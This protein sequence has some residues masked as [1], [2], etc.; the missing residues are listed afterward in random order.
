MCAIDLKKWAAGPACPTVP[1]GT[2]V[3]V[4]VWNPADKA[5]RMITSLPYSDNRMF[6]PRVRCPEPL[7][8]RRRR[9][10]QPG[11]ASDDHPDCPPGRA[12]RRVSTM[13]PAGPSLGFA[14]RSGPHHQT[15]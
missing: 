7:E 2:S 12:G 11:L 8:L 1:M 4:P 14:W 15:D 6:L 13:R 3:V 5:A 9:A 10:M